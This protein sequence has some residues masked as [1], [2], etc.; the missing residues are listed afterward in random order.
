MKKLVSIIIPVYNVE[1]YLTFCLDSLLNQTY[2]DLEVIAVD[3]GST[4]NSLAILNAYAAMD[5]RLRVISQANSGPS[6]ARNLGLSMCHGEY[7]T[8]MDS[9][10]WAELTLIEKLVNALET[11]QSDIAI[12]GHWIAGSHYKLKVRSRKSWVLDQKQAVKMIL[13]DKVIKNY[14][15][16]KMIRRSLLPALQFP[17]DQIY[18]DVRSVYKVFLQASRFSLLNEPLYYYRMRQGSITYSLP[19][20]NAA[21]MKKAYQEQRHEIAKFYPELISCT[22][23]NLFKANFLILYTAAR[24]KLMMIKPV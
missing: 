16:G 9:D 15:W 21:E 7:I 8:F 4:D 2:E 5:Q 1:D 18:E 23:M 3:D 11:D 12:C 13:Q 20:M 22:D 19:A 17:V 10:D 14:A 24:D 6:A